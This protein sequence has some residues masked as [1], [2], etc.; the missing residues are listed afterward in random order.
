MVISDVKTD[1]VRFWQVVWSTILYGSG[2]LHIAP[3][4]YKQRQYDG[5]EIPEDS[6]DEEEKRSYKEWDSKKTG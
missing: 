1:A 2:V 3:E 6:S 4:I 5:D